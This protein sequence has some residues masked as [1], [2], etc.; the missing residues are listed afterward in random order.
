MTGQVGELV[1]KPPGVVRIK[2]GESYSTPHPDKYRVPPTTL[3]ALAQPSRCQLVRNVCVSYVVEI[4]Y[5]SRHS[6]PVCGLPSPTH[7]TWRSSTGII[8][9]FQS[10]M[11]AAGDIYLDPEYLE[12]EK[13]LGARPVFRGP[14]ENVRAIAA[15]WS[16]MGAAM[17]PPPD[18]SVKTSMVH[19]HQQELSSLNRWRSDMLNR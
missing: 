11:A 8:S 13:A 18:D 1:L 2:S 4:S 10:K 12:I 5:I 7:F 19:L 9:D 16:A 6:Q 17:R 15:Q 14:V 3:C